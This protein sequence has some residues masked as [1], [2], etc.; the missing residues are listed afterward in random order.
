MYPVL[1]QGPM[2]Y[3]VTLNPADTDTTVFATGGDVVTIYVG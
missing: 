1:L 2:W 3:A